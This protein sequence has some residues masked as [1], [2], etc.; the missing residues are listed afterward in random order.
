VVLLELEAM[1]LGW[2]QIEEVREAVLRLR[3]R[4]GKVA[5]YLRGGGLK[6]YFLAAAAE[7]IYCHPHSRLSIVGIRIEVFFFAELLAR[8][9]AKAEFVRVAEYKSRPEQFERTTSTEP[10]ASQRQLMLTDTWNH[11]VR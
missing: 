5:V 2:A 10:S 7:R 11:V 9:G 6:D 3:A 4:G 8:L 1:R